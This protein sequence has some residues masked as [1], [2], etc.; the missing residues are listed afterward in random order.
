MKITKIHFAFFAL[1]LTIAA[2]L[3][4]PRLA[5]PPEGVSF[6]EIAAGEAA[7]KSIELRN[8]FP[9]KIALGFMFAVLGALLLPGVGARLAEL[10]GK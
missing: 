4:A 6:G 10:I 1:N 8:V 9:A 7:S 3:A 5:V 2:A